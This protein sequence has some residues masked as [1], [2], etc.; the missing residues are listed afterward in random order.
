MINCIRLKQCLKKIE[1]MSE[2]WEMKYEKKKAE[3]NELGENNKTLSSKLQT[4]KFEHQ[5]R[6]IREEN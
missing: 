3:N 4:L 2:K 1:N 6:K 5:L